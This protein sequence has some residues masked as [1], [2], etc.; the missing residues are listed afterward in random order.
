M[1]TTHPPHKIQNVRVFSQK[2]GESHTIC[3]KFQKYLRGLLLI[4]VLTDARE[5]VHTRTQMQRMQ[6]MKIYERNM[7]GNVKRRSGIIYL[8]LVPKMEHQNKTTV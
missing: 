5:A 7:L 4:T 3:S 2:V 1:G 6:Y 8:S